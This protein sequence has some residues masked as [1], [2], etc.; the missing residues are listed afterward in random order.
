MTALDELIR[1][2]ER[3]RALWARHSEALR[4]RVRAL[5]PETGG[6][7]GLA[8]NWGNAAA[9]EAIRAANQRWRKYADMHDKRANA[10]MRAHV[11]GE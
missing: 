7:L 6:H 5:H 1:L 11:R 9:K 8:H 4:N 10:L 3:K 2:G